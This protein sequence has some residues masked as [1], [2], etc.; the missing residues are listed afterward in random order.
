MR[1]TQR[2]VGCVAALLLSSL[3]WLPTFPAIAGEELSAKSV[4]ELL[5]LAAAEGET[6]RNRAGAVRALARRDA[7]KDQ[8]IVP[9]LRRLLESEQDF[10]VRLALHYALACH[11][12]RMALYGLLESLKRTDHLGEY[13]LSRAT[14][15]KFHWNYDAWKAHIDGLTDAAWREFQRR[16]RLPRVADDRDLAG[17]LA[18][19]AWFDGLGYPDLGKRPF[20]R[21]PG[22]PDPLPEH[23]EE[24]GRWILGF[25]LED[26]EK[27]F[28]YLGTDLRTVTRKKPA[29]PE[30]CPYEVA[31]LRKTVRE[32][33]DRIRDWGQRLS[34]SCGPDPFEIQQ[35]TDP[36]R[37]RLFVIARACAAR[38]HDDLAME[39]WTLAATMGPW[40][41][42]H[43]PWSLLAGLEGEMADETWRVWMDGLTDPRRSFRD[44]VEA[45]RVWARRYAS[46]PPPEVIAERLRVLEQMAAAEAEREARPV[47]PLEEMQVAE[48]VAALVDRLPET[49]VWIGSEWIRGERSF[50]YL[51]EP[52]RQPP[53]PFARLVALG[54]DAVPRLIGALDDHRFTRTLH[55]HNSGKGQWRGWRHPERVCD[56]AQ[57][58]LE[59]IALRQFPG[60]KGNLSLAVDEGAEDVKAAVQAWWKEIQD[61]G[62]ERTLIDGIRAGTGASVDQARRLVSKYPRAAEEALLQGIDAS[63]DAYARRGL[64]DLLAHVKGERSQALLLQEGTQGKTLDLRLAAARALRARGHP[65]GLRA[66]LAE[67]SRLCA[68]SR[69][70]SWLVGISARNGLLEFLATCEDPDVIGAL[71]RGLRDAGAPLRFGVIAVMPRAMGYEYWGRRSEP[72]D[73]ADPA[74]ERRRRPVEEAVQALLVSQLLNEDESGSIYV[75]CPNTS[76]TRRVC[77]AAAAMLAHFWPGTYRFDA[78]GSVRARDVQRFEAANVWRRK[79]GLEPLPLPEFRGVTPLPEAVTQPLLDRLL[80]ADDAPA[81][82]EAAAAVERAG[83]G[84]L[85]AVKKALDDL[86]VDDPTGK[87][88]DRLIEVRETLVSLARRLACVVY[89]YVI[90]EGSMAP[91]EGLRRLLDGRKGKPL[92]AAGFVSIL[93]QVMR[94]PPEGATGIR[95]RAYREGHDTGFMLYLFLTRERVPQPGPQKGWDVSYGLQAGDEGLA[96][97]G[98]SVSLEYGREEGSWALY[99]AYYAEALEHALVTSPETPIWARTSIVRVDW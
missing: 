56:L 27:A 72:A 3:V 94:S 50:R 15:R 10:H 29:D 90:E 65:A 2:C 12:E 76:N 13:Y 62:E 14:E 44:H 19:V 24:R 61:V 75:S 77:D 17:F 85:P 11:G 49:R 67:W 58:A 97:G 66:M 70:R 16:H 88:A 98:G 86:E 99:W 96:G 73:P 9:A 84:A 33:L 18:A 4:E 55:W 79:Q 81:R 48:R 95:L 46:D 21:R 82:S 6:P 43:P 78:K 74:S 80:A 64:L 59:R 37:F 30:A 69:G 45:Y 57:A 39:L 32:G 23:H 7:T 41:P 52:P 36:Q 68:E 1:W 83:L 71:E 38:G 20:I 53:S 34:C 25:L 8:P 60:R 92:T 31:D 63:E 35:W 51:N 93:L 47:R 22:D 87:S 89:G 28:T 54:F 91:D 26:G 5:G 42:G 40:P